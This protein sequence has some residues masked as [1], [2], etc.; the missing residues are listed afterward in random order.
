ME[1]ETDIQLP[2]DPQDNQLDNSDKP[3]KDQLINKKEEF[4]E[5]TL[6]KASVPHYEELHAPQPPGA[7]TNETASFYIEH[8]EGALGFSWEVDQQAKKATPTLPAPFLSGDKDGVL[9][10]EQ[11]ISGVYINI[12]RSA[13][14]W[15]GDQ[16]KMRWGNSTFYTTVG[17]ANGRS[18]PRMIQ[19]LN[20]EKLGSYKTG[21]VEI[22]YEV[23]RR[24]RLVGVSET[25]QIVLRSDGKNHP[26]TLRGRAIRRR[27]LQE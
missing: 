13:K 26:K 7:T 3:V 23:V 12:P 18:G 22:R 5:S 27:K 2:I 14:I 24:A 17:E 9:T 6:R 8:L 16:L 11:L 15:S 19:Y 25:L 21:A 4:D 20:A 1:D 10:E